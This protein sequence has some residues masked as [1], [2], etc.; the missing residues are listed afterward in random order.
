MAVIFQKVNVFDWFEIFKWSVSFSGKKID[1]VVKYPEEIEVKPEDEVIS[2]NYFLMPWMINLHTHAAMSLFKSAW[3]DLPLH[4]WLNNK[5]FPLESKFVT[6][7]MVYYASL[8]SMIESLRSWVTTM[9]DMYFFE[10]DVARA[11]K[12][13][14]MKVFIGECAFN[15]P[16]PSWKNADAVL[17]GMESMIQKYKGDEFVRVA[18]TP[19]SPYLTDEKYLL[20]FKELSDKYGVP[21]HIHMSETR[22]EVSEYMDK[23]WKTEIE[24]FYELWILSDRFIWAHCTYLVDNDLTLLDKAK[25]TVVHCLSSNM[26]LWSW[27]ARTVDMIELW[28]NLAIG[29][30]GS[31]SANNLNL[32]QEVE[33]AAKLQKWFLKDPAAFKSLDALKAITSNAGRPLWESFGTI[34]EWWFA[35]LVLIDCSSPE[36]YPIYDIWAAILYWSSQSDI[37]SVYVNGKKVVE[38]WKILTIDVDGIRNEFTKFVN[39]VYEYLR[40]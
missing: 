5:I 38:R 15:F 32:I 25:S 1:K 16:W 19:H 37:K 4:E 26:K 39:E 28:I 40:K 24:R 20:K 17:D 3:E 7:E 33:F 35:D 36:L 34:Q 14:N 6:S 11:A 12:D 21:Y 13:I 22:K 9:N 30:D 31:A 29:T 27:I 23:Y 18:C 8:W 2:G 10:D